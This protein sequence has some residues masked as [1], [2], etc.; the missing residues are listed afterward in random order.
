MNN[1]PSMICNGNE[2]KDLYPN[3]KIVTVTD[4]KALIIAGF[5]NA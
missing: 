2:L 3:A 5:H 4:A 1:S